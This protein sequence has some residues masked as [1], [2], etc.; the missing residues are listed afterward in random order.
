M[1][2]C[3]IGLVRIS[4]MRRPP[5]NCS[6]KVSCDTRQ[7]HK[8]VGDEL[9]DVA[10][11][12]VAP[13]GA[14]AQDAIERRADAAELRRQVQQLAKLPVPAD[15][16]HVLVEH[17][18]AMPHLVERRLQ[19][20]AVVLQRFGGII[21]QAQGRLAAGVAAAQQQRQHQARGCGTDGA[22]Q[23]MLREAQQMDVG[24]RVGRERRVAA[25]RVFG[26]RALG[27]LGAQIARHRVLQVAGRD[28]TCA[29]G[30]TPA[31]S[32]AA[33][34]RRARTR[35]PAA[36]RPARAPSAATPTTNAQTLAAMLHSTPCVS[37]SNC[38]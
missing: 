2:P 22:G 1:P 11:A 3:G 7:L 25:V 4:R 37:G 19:Q 21:E 9:V 16:P 35:A 5:S 36:A 38:R 27:A 17:A 14:G 23:Q 12:E 28:R 29:T 18:E 32:A 6:W 33:A 20:V 8:P 34:G 24:F 31:T 30:G 15:Q 26:E 10:G 13:L